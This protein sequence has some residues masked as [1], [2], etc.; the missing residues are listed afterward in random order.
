[1]N[2]KMNVSP[3]SSASRQ[4]VAF[5]PVYTPQY[6]WFASM[7]DTFRE[8]KLPLILVDVTGDGL[9][10]SDRPG[11]VLSFS[12]ARLGLWVT[13]FG[14][15]VGAALHLRCGAERWVLGGRDHR[16]AAG[17][18][19]DAPD[20]DIV[21]AWVWT[22]EFD[23]I[24]NMASRRGQLQLAQ[25]APDE[26]TRCL[27]FRRR[28][29]RLAIDVAADG[30]RVGDLDADELIASASPA[31]LTAT[32]ETHLWSNQGRPFIRPQRGYRSP[33]MVMNVPGWRQVSI[34]CN[35][36]A[37]DPEGILARPPFSWRP[38]LRERFSW[39]GTVRKRIETPDYAVSGMD[40]L[41]LVEVCGLAPYLEDKRRGEG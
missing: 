15:P 18:R 26:M 32:P 36:A 20:A 17:T 3:T 37:D 22:S 4:F 13:A 21:D 5:L 11:D 2:V 34:E 31:Q 35:D 1:M 40:W 33:T 28:G 25:P 6:P 12:D 29:P 7:K 23:E 24:L 27:L 8:P 41:T 30:I 19:L 14:M 16:L 39:R 9:T 38:K 10:I